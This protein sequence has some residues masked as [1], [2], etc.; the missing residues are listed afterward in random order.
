MTV[1]ASV[2]YLRTYSAFKAGHP[3]NR[4]SVIDSKRFPSSIISVNAGSRVSFNADVVN[5][6]LL[7]FLFVNE[8]GEKRSELASYRSTSGMLWN[9]CNPTNGYITAIVNGD[10]CEW[11]KLHYDARKNLHSFREERHWQISTI[12]CI[13]LAICFNL[14]CMGFAYRASFIRAIAR[15]PAAHSGSNLQSTFL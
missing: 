5:M 9:E 10:S 4:S 7:R 14:L 2:I 1:I 8:K 15:V 12:N 6:F 11:K 13:F 3:A